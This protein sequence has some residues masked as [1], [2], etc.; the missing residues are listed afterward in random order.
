MEGPEFFH[1][2]KMASPVCSDWFT[3]LSFVGL[4]C[5][6]R[7]A[8]LGIVTAQ[9]PDH[10]VRA[11]RVPRPDAMDLCAVGGGGAGSVWWVSRGGVAGLARGSCRQHRTGPWAAA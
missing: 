7:L 8:M 3:C 2:V 9:L 10:H 1:T 5:P 11:G 4:R 6:S